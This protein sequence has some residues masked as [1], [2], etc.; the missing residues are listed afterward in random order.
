MINK[1]SRYLVRALRHDPSI[2]NLTVDKRGWVDVSS[3]LKSLSIDKP[4][5]DQIVQI[6]DKQRFE[7]NDNQTKIRASQGHSLNN[8]EVY[9]DW[10][11][12]IPTGDLYHGTAQQFVNQILS[13]KLISKSRTHVHLSK[14]I[15]TAL[16]VGSRH[17][18]VVL[19]SV[20][21]I[22][23]YEDGYKFLESKNGVILIDEV[24]SRYLKKLDN[25]HINNIKFQL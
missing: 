6:N 13:S 23:M 25:G 3:V 17:G 20:D 21:A 22:K 18:K 16:K 8:V 14:D 7:Y 11:V 1:K 19:L 9:K 4:T 10:N 2:L 5:L 15:P 24:P 12:Y